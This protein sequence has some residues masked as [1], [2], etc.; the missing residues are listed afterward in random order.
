[1]AFERELSER[2]RL[3]IV[4]KRVVKVNASWLCGKPGEQFRE[5]TL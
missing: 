2:D 4:L 1:M 5:G 3:R